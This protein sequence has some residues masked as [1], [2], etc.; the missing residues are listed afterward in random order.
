MSAAVREAGRELDADVAEALG[1]TGRRVIYAWDDRKKHARPLISFADPEPGSKYGE[2]LCR[3]D[4]GIFVTEDGKKLDR[5]IYYA[6]SVSTDIA[7]AFQVV[8]AMRAKG[9]EVTVG[10]SAREKNAFCE[11]AKASDGGSDVEYAA[12]PAIAICLAALAALESSRPR[13]QETREV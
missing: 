5:G 10:V 13:P 7:A 1:A 12:T 8:E 3:G 6:K 2:G 4:F 11:I 9:Y